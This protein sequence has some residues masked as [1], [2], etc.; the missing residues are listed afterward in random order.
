[1]PAAEVRPVVNAVRA[2]RVGAQSR[3]LVLYFFL[4]TTPKKEV[5]RKKGLAGPTTVGEPTV[6]FTD[7]GWYTLQAAADQGSTANSRIEVPMSCGRGWVNPGAFAKTLNVSSRRVSA[8][9]LASWPD[10]R[11][12]ANRRFDSETPADH[13]RKSEDDR[14][15]SRVRGWWPGS[16]PHY[17][18]SQPF[19]S[20]FLNPRNSSYPGF[21]PD[22]RRLVT[23]K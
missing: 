7:P 10:R 2:K 9:S 20:D 5:A 15:S 1:T 21:C 6:R 22:S 14:R 11:P 16:N 13:P 4:W 8:N 19:C 17:D 3:L 18:V 23:T 12:S